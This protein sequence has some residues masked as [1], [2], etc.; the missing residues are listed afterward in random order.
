MSAGTFAKRAWDAQLP[1][2]SHAIIQ[3]SYSDLQLLTL[4]TALVHFRELCKQRGE[5]HAINWLQ[6]FVDGVADGALLRAADVIAGPEIATL[7][8]AQAGRLP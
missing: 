1:K 2:L 5:E 6:S 7:R 8:L 4:M 3:Q